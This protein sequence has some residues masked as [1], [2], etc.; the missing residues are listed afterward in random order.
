MR[1]CNELKDDM[2]VL[3]ALDDL[4]V[5]LTFMGEAVCCPRERPWNDH[6]LSG[7]QFIFDALA[8]DME[9]LRAK[10]AQK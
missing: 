7:A 1:L 10:I 2:D 5:I 4:A 3:D 9:E 8:A 6:Q